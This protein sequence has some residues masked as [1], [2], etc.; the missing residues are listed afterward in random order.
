MPGAFDEASVRAFARV[1]T[2]PILFALSNPSTLSEARPEDLVRWTQ[3]RAILAT[4]SPFPSVQ[5][6]GRP[7]RVAQVNNMLIFPGVGMGA[8]VSRARKVTDAMFSVAARAC[9]DQVPPD[10]LAEGTILP[11]VGDIRRVSRAVALAVALE[12]VRS[13]VAA[14]QTRSQLEER[15]ELETW[16]P[17]YM[18]LVR[19]D[20]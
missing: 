18:E 10:K 1:A 9:A 2:R 11:A 16:E 15:L 8:W 17:R 5:Q 12:A 14:E 13:G 20:E 7:V 19:A 3:G 4:G 6:G